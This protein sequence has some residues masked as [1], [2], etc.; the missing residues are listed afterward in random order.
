MRPRGKSG[1]VP[2]TGG[3]GG[4]GA[5][6]VVS[7]CARA[8]P[9]VIVMALTASS[10]PTTAFRLISAPCDVGPSPRLEA[11]APRAGPRSSGAKLRAYGKRDVT[12]A[13]LHCY[14]CNMAPRT[15]KEPPVSPSRPH[16]APRHH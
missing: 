6:R 8:D 9:A 1:S 10:Q 13:F 15:E 14:V 2:V 5:V 16:S 12:N 11:P 7:V 4:S 3:G